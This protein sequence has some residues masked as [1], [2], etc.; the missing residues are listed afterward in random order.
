MNDSGKGLAAGLLSYLIWGFFP[1]FFYLLRDVSPFEILIQRIIWSFVLVFIFVLLLKRFISLKTA[2]LDKKVMLGLLLSAFLISV[3]WLV[4]IWAVGQGRVLESSLGYFITPLVSV[5]LARVFL[6]EKLDNWRIASIVLAASG[7][8]WI[9]FKLGYLPWVSLLLASSFGLYGLVRKQIKVDTLTGLTI[10]TFILLPIALIYWGWLESNNASVLFNGDTRTTLLLMA[11]GIVT[12]TPL[13]L[14]AY[15]AKKMSLMAIGFLMYINPSI[16]FFIAVEILNEP[17]NQ[18]VLISF[19][20]IWC[21][22]VVFTLGSIKTKAKQK[23]I[24]PA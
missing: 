7:I 23:M 14:F 6:Q 9:L 19:Y 12:A 22:L 20:F 4:F 3:N 10:E 2:V 5:F 24:K 21:A 17:L 11:S 16:Q 15:A 1:L 8:F 18:D 13:L